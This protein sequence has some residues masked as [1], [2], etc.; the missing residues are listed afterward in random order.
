MN[1]ASTKISSSGPR[2]RPNQRHAFGGVWRLTFR[3][4]LSL[5]QL[6]T[7]AG[8]LALLGLVARSSI[9]RG[10]AAEYFEWTGNFFL[11]VVV[12]ILAFLSG[13]GA[14]RDDL[15]AGSVDYLFTRPVRRPAF[16]V[17][18]YLSH[19]ACTQITYL[20]AFGVLVAVG[21]FRQV[22]NLTAGLPLLL[23][24]QVITIAAF[25]ALGFCCA[26]LV[27]RYLIIGLL[28]AGVVEAGVGQIP[29]QLSGLSMTRQVRE[30]LEPLM[31]SASEATLAGAFTTTISLLVFSS[32]F[33]AVAALVFSIREFSGTPARD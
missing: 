32:V 10:D 16:I 22:P 30:L 28:Y 9:T 8:M 11:G 27:S 19:L 23:L 33:I 13:A 31:T 1:A 7:T 15:K 20:L 5:N 21:V 29:T 25:V 18:R 14:M 4:W 6:L 17:F 24:A 26:V 2:V 12:P 3:R